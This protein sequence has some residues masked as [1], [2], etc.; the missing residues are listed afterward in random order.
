MEEAIFDTVNDPFEKNNI[1][2]ENPL[3]LAQYRKETIQWYSELKSKYHNR[4]STIRSDYLATIAET[5]TYGSL[6]VARTYS[7]LKQKKNEA[8]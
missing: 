6:D 7:K 2:E 4:Y 8:L 3:L 1:A 5:V